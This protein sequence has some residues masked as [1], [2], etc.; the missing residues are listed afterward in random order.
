MSAG[1][2]PVQLRNLH[3]VPSKKVTTLNILIEFGTNITVPIII[4]HHQSSSV[5]PIPTRTLQ[6]TYG[7]H[8]EE[9]QRAEERKCDHREHSRKRAQRATA[10]KSLRSGLDS[11]RL[12]LR[13]S[14]PDVR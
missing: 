5:E 9:E 4:S 3:N 6:C 13:Q 8:S 12:A 2:L 11:E 14:Q 7:T 10:L 1:F